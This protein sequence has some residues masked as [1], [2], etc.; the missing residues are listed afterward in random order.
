[1][2]DSRKAG[3]LIQGCFI[4]GLPGDTKESSKRTVEFAKMLLPD[5][6]QFYSLYAY[7]GTE[8]WAWAKQNG[9]LVT[10]DPTYLND[11]FGQHR[12]NVNLPGFSAAEANQMCHQA[13]KEYYLSRKY[14]F[15]KAKQCMTSWEEFKRTFIAA[16]TFFWYLAT[17]KPLP[18]EP[19]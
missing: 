16:K 3:I 17:G 15:Y 6:V 1:M 10:E 11:E 19:M 12:G 7:P 13:L 4:V 9:Y 14:I 5:T 2:E 18:T 8:A